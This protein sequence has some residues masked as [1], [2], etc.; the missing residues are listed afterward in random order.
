MASNLQDTLQ[1]V[2]N[3]S[4]ILIEKYR[5]LL[6]EKRRVDAANESLSSKN[7]ALEKEIERLRQENEYLRLA[8]SIS[9][10]PEQTEAN[11]AWISKLVRDIDKCIS[12]LT[13]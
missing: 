10:T 3:K 13:D 12:Q 2:V 5:A 1:R 11:R 9:S 4:E 6:E 7:V 8:R